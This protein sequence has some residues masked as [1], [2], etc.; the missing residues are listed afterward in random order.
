MW[1]AVIAKAQQESFA[2]HELAK[3]G[4]E[5]FLPEC[6]ERRRVGTKMQDARSALFPRYLFC[7]PGHLPIRS[8]MGTRGVSSIIRSQATGAPFYVSEAVIDGLRAWLEDQGG[9]IDFRPQR[10]KGFQINDRVTIVDGPF[11][12]RFGIVS[13]ASRRRV[14]LLLDILGQGVRHSFPNDLVRLSDKHESA[15]PA[16]AI[17]ATA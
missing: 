16:V 17:R 10:A 3:Q 9:V 2:A 15:C 4:T 11:Q 5:V 1:L 14:T 6:I 7:Q 13:W 8:V 12:G